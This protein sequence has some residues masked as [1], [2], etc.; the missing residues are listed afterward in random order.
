MAQLR[1]R[2]EYSSAWARQTPDSMRDSCSQ[3]ALSRLHSQPGWFAPGSN[4]RSRKA[5]QAPALLDLDLSQPEAVAVTG[6][7]CRE[8]GQ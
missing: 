5:A 1:P 2:A 4:M 7:G 8:L 6:L 3:G